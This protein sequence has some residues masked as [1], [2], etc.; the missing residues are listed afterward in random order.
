[1]NRKIEYDEYLSKKLRSPKFAQ[2]YIESL[3]E[4]EDGMTLEDALR[5]AISV[6]GISEFADLASIPQPRVSEFLSKRKKLMQKSLDRF[7]S[8][9]KLVTVLVPKRI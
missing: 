3:I 7:L 5:H 6:M 4:G 1:M 8:P 2:A 9:F